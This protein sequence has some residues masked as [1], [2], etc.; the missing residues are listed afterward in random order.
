MCSN[1]I[2]SHS[3]KRPI[4]RSLCS[5]REMLQS[6]NHGLVIHTHQVP[7]DLGL[8]KVTAWAVLVTKPSHSLP[9]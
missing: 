1:E 6:L 3:L 4:S 7:C 9:S 8:L 5:L 2:S